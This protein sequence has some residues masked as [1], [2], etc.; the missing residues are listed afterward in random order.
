MHWGAL[1]ALL[2]GAATVA[3]S[4]Q[5]QSCGAPVIVHSSY[6]EDGATGVA[7][8]AALYIYGPELEASSSEVTLEDDSGEAV[9]IDVQAAPG[10]LLI[11]AFLGL[12]PNTSYELTVALA[13]GGDEWSASFTTGAGPA[14]VVQLRAP[15]VGVSVIDQDQGACG[16]VSAICVIGSVSARRT[17]EVVVRGEVLS[18]GDGEPTPVYMASR[19]SVPANAC[20]EVRMREPG[21]VVSEAT[22]LCGDELGRFELDANA[23]APTSCQPYSA[24]PDNDDDDDDDES[25]E[26][27]GCAMGAS[28]AA[29][30]AGGAL[31]GLVASLAA[32]VTARWRRAR[33]GAR[34]G[35]RG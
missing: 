30:G 29:S 1:L 11:D 33:R 21:G 20:I 13:S 31:F 16:V 19:E 22:R 24:V 28:G 7:T 25:S 4:A 15:D 18:L 12:T 8:N 3:P 35:V 5:A 23:P 27:G 2:L 14:T 9:S 6:P 10:G 26:S 32:L 17:L 34:R